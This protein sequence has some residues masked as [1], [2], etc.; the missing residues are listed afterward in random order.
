MSLVTAQISLYAEGKQARKTRLRR[1]FSGSGI[2]GNGDAAYSGGARARRDQVCGAACPTRS[3]SASPTASSPDDHQS[4]GEYR[5]R[6]RTS[7][8]FSDA[9]EQVCLWH[10]SAFSH[11]P[12]LERLY[13][14]LV[15]LPQAA[16]HNFAMQQQK[17]DMAAAHAAAMQHFEEA[18]LNQA[19]EEVERIVLDVRQVSRA[20]AH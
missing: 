3:R 20:A 1:R 10:A 9:L 7:S 19:V 12:T 13:V 2:G 14:C 17:K 15:C 16:Q 11:S 6:R 5:R 8:T 4:G 18:T